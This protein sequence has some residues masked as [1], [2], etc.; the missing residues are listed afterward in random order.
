[1]FYKDEKLALVVDGVNL[2]G[3]ARALGFEIDYRKLREAFETRGKIQ[4]AA[5][6]TTVLEQEDFT[7]LRPLLDWL[8]YNGFQVSTK[9]AR[10][11]TDS[12]GRRR[13]KGSMN[14]E[15]AVD[16]LEI[17][18]HIDH[19][20]LFSGDGELRAMAEAVQRRGVRVTVVSSM[21]TQPPM[22]SDDLRRQADHFIELDNLK[23]TVSRPAREPA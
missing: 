3:V 18:D 19:L 14:V 4:R 8:D 13:I 5:Y 23:A 15:M 21:K 17:A 9:P 1:M 7:P 6:Y 2:H 12:S 10:E 11:Y 16:L 22:V 20:V